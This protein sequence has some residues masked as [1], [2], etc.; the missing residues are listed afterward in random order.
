MSKPT[1]D[2]GIL[3]G[4]F[5][6]HSTFSDDARSS[7]AENVAAAAAA[8]LHTVRLVDHVRQS[9][10]WV[11]EYLAAVAALEVPDGLTVLTGVEA[12]MLT[13]EGELD[14]PALPAGI[15]RI[16]IADHQFPT[17]AGPVGPSEIIE[18][19]SAGL[20]PT[21]ALDDCIAALIAAMERYP[22][23]QLAHCFSILPKVGLS[24]DDLSREHLEAWALTAARTDTYVEVNEKWGCPGPRAIAALRAAGATL[25][26]STDSHDAATVGSYSRVRELLLN[27]EATP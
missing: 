10:S 14:I 20:S 3:G 26:A 17:A 9:T 4:D 27:A 12:K 2:S 21:D 23:N 8:G 5:H 19:I 16:L 24:E 22:G 13:T 18:R 15:D 25:V 11:P 6:V 1:A 7:L